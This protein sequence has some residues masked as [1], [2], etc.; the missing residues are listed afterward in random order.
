M[1]TEIIMG[2]SHLNQGPI[3][4]TARRPDVPALISANAL[5]RW[6]VQDGLQEW[7]DWRRRRPSPR[8][9]RESW[10][11]AARAESRA[12]IEAGELDHDEIVHGWIESWSSDLLCAAD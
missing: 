12:L 6:T 10:I 3:L 1:P 9:P 7:T 5:S 11:S 8:C 4:Q 2:L